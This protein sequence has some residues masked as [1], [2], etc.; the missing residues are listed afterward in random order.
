MVESILFGLGLLTAVFVGVNVGGSSTG[1]CFG[2]AVGSNLV[3]LR[4]GSAL[5]AFFALAGG[6]VIG[7]NVVDTMGRN[8][9]PAEHFTLTASIAVMF[10]IGVALVFSNYLRISAST[11]QIAVVAIVG[12]GIALGVLNWSVFGVILVWW[13]LSGILA[14]W[15][16][17]VVGRYIYDEFVEFFDMSDSLTSHL[18]VIAVGCYMAFSAGASNVAN[19]VAPLVGSG[20]LDMIP[21]VILGGLA[22]GIGAFW[23]GPRTMDTIGNEITDMTLEAALIVELIA[24]TTIT[25]LSFAGIPASLAIVA[26]LAVMGLGWG[27]ATRRVPIV[28]EIGPGE[29]TI[30]DRRRM[31]EDSLN[32]YNLGT[33][34]RVVMTWMVAPLI[35]GILALITFAVGI[36]FGF[37]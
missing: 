31:R 28:R 13:L 33:S 23:I 15:V 16:S 6:V 7:P 4:Q 34:R 36:Y 10:F 11:S 5:M 32:L 37:I 3:T 14:F 27:R 21:A 12:M 24:G 18:L 30:K 2:P 20:E 9:V 35:A 1:V 8:L 26:T 22:M 29:L 17:A 25:L 19:A